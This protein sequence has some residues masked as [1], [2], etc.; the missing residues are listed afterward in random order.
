VAHNII[1]GTTAQESTKVCDGPG[2]NHYWAATRVSREEIL[3]TL[4]TY[5]RDCTI[6]LEYLDTGLT[7]IFAILIRLDVIRYTETQA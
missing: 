4:L 7:I 3:Q 5:V 1:R 2:A 6:I